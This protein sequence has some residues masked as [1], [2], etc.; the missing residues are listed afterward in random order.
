MVKILKPAMAVLAIL[1]GLYPL[2]Y[3]FADRKFGLLSSKPNSVL[4]DA[5]W[6]VGFY[7]HIFFG[8]IAMLIG[9][10]QFSEKLRIRKL[11]WHR[12]IGKVYVIA[13]L[14]S[15]AAGV[16]ISFYATGGIVASL[17]FLG[18]GLSWFLTTYKGYTLIR[19][20]NIDAHQEMMIYSYALCLSAVTLRIYLP[21]LVMAFQD[22]TPAYLIVA[23]LCW[24]PNVLVAYLIIKGVRRRRAGFT[25]RR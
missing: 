3:L 15:A 14:V 20:M 1:I 16:Y 2:I 21:L 13:A 23:W 4:T 17:G 12:N 5:F 18:L 22:F 10:L 25:Q 9:W 6:N 11:I 24:V 7:T 8:G 19:T